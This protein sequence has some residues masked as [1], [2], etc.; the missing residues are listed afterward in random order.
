MTEKRIDVAVMGGG[1]AGN[2]FARQLKMTKPELE[3]VVF[4][5]DVER[6]YKVGES[7]VEIAANYLTRKQK[8]NRYLFMNQLPKNS[9]RFFFDTQARDGDRKS[10]V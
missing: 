5:R 3:I 4:E 9:L 7:T 2:L 10:V 1:L 6:S 8:L